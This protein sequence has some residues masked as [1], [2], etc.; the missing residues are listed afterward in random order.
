MSKPAKHNTLTQHIFKNLGKAIY[1]EGDP[2]EQL[3][4]FGGKKG[5]GI[6]IEKSL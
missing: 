3:N 4:K 2:Q 1:E 5:E 6:W